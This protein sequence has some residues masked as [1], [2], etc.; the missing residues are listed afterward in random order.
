MS[1]PPLNYLQF[2][3]IIFHLAHVLFAFLLPRPGTRSQRMSVIVH[4]LLVFGTTSK[5][6][7]SVLHFINHLLTYLH[8]SKNNPVMYPKVFLHEMP[9][10]SQSSPFFG[11]RTGSEYVGFHTLRPGLCV[12][13][14]VP[15]L[16]STINLSCAFI[17]YIGFLPCDA[18]HKRCVRRP[19]IC[20][21]RV[22]CWKE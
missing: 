14:K 8:E 13:K 18:K 2:C 10:L 1:P 3:A 17:Q 7:I 4:H 6:T 16:S 12:H 21:I 5:H 22:F 15:V 11:L 20:H 9:F 19:S